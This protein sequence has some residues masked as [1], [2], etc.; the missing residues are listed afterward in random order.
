V[1]SIANDLNFTHPVQVPDGFLGSALPVPHPAAGPLYVKLRD[2]SAVIN[3]TTLGVQIL[4][5][6]P[7]EVTRS[8]S[9]QPAVT[10]APES[11]PPAPPPGDATPAPTPAGAEQRHTN[12]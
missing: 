12:P 5:A 11:P 8:S 4:P 9:R 2:D 7:D 1:D 3:S 6:A 10:A